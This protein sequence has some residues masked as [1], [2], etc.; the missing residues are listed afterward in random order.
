MLSSGSYSLLRERIRVVG[1]ARVSF[2]KRKVVD[3]D[4][5]LVPSEPNHIY[6]RRLSNFLDSEL[7]IRSV[8]NSP[9]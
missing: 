9:S 8:E 6:T 3:Q 2:V 5:I 7:Q 4:G 1:A